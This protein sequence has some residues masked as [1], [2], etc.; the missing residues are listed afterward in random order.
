MIYTPHKESSIKWIIIYDIWIEKTIYIKLNKS[1]NKTLYEETL[2]TTLFNE[3]E[4]V[5]SKDLLEKSH[6]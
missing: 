1:K 3:P 2:I 4:R 5:C 6:W